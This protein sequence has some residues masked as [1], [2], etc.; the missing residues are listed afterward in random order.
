MGRYLIITRSVGLS[1]IARETNNTHPMVLDF[2][3]RLSSREGQGKNRYARAF[4][5]A[6]GNV[7][8]DT[9]AARSVAKF[10]LRHARTLHAA[11]VLLRNRQ[12]RTQLRAR[13]RGNLG[14]SAADRQDARNFALALQNLAR[15][16]MAA[17]LG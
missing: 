1:G 3:H 11:L 14:N 13:I 12:T 6:A 7:P 10:G 5:W 15:K 16:A 17:R 2:W 9:L 8:K 4:V